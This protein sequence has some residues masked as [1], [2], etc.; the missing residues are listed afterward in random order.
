LKIIDFTREHIAEAAALALANYEEECGYVSAL[1]KIDK[2][3]DLA[4][5]ADNGL[6]VAAFDNCK[7]VGFMCGHGIWK[8]SWD[9]SGLSSV[10]S[11][12]HGNGTIVENRAEI[13][14]RL[15]QAAG[16]KWVRAGAASHGICLYAHDN[17]A[18][19]QFYRYGFGL[20][21][22]NAI[23]EM[24]EIAVSDCA[25]YEFSE[26]AP[27]NI[28]EVLPLENKLNESCADSPFFMRKPP[29]SEAEFMSEYANARSVYIV[30]RHNNDI[31]AF[32]RAEPGGQSFI[33]DIPNYLHCAGLYCLPEH[34]G[35]GISQ[36]LLNR[37]LKKLKRQGIT[38]F[39]TTYESFNP[40]GS[41]FWLKYFFEYFHC[42]VRRIDEN[43]LTGGL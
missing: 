6:G 34:R 23:R 9:I 8:N 21:V 10:F 2:V 19:E 43:I 24:E 38:R 27:D 40:S 5:F 30:A 39:G 20:R 12:L 26:L 13:Y 32:I 14:A 33:T 37:L 7:M 17:E 1:Q 29:N 18:K 4:G 16:E 15:Y 11:Q 22:V 3:A 35:K 36:N 25:D 41:G 31:V 28:L 42:V